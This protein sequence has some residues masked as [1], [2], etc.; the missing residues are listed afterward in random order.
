MI[1]NLV[2]ITAL[3]RFGTISATLPGP[4]PATVPSNFLA[5]SIDCTLEVCHWMWTALLAAT[6][7]TQV[8]FAASNCT[9]AFLSA[10][11]TASVSLTMASAVPFLGATLAT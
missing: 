7:P 3:S 4:V 11:S 1:L 2:P 6:R 9:A 8:S 5:S 10:C